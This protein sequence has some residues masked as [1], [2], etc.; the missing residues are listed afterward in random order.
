MGELKLAGELAS[1]LGASV[2]RSL[3]FIPNSV[4]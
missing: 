2:S 1:K 4:C 3:S